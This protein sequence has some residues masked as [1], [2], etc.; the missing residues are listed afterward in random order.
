MPA[1]FGLAEIAGV[2]FGFAL[3]S[4]GAFF[5]CVS[6]VFSSVWLYFFHFCFL[7]LFSGFYSFPP[8]PPPIMNLSQP[9]L[10]TFN[11]TG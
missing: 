11:G 6:G 4:L 5:L 8:A 3:S 9:I 2:P 7:R 10:K 1:H